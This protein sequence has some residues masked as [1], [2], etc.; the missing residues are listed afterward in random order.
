MW[1]RAFGKDDGE[2]E[3]MSIGQFRTR[4]GSDRLTF[5]QSEEEEL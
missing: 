2:R 3:V 4:Y 5:H 1:V